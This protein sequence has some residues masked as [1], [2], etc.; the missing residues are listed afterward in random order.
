MLLSFQTAT[1]SRFVFSLLLKSVCS[2]VWCQ[3]ADPV[4]A[5]RSEGIYTCLAL[6]KRERLSS[7]IKQRLPIEFVGT[8]LGR[9]LK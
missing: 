5:L 6:S 4:R 8:G 1:S 3:T 7:T 2:I 9:V